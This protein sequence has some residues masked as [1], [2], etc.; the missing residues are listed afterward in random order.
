MQR[1]TDD[2]LML[3]GCNMNDWKKHRY[4]NGQ[5]AVE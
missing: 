5:E 3:V 4:K 2:F 1:I